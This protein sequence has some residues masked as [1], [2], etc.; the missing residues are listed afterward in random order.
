MKAFRDSRVAIAIVLVL[1]A[2]C[3]TADFAYQVEMD[4][5]RHQVGD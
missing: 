5:I 1:Y 2:I 3:G 4:A